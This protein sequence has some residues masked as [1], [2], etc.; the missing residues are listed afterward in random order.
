VRPRACPDVPVRERELDF[1][2]VL[3]FEVPRD[4]DCER[5][6]DVFAFDVVPLR[7]D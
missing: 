5:L 6:C 4:V 2:R 7:R 3:D 1:D